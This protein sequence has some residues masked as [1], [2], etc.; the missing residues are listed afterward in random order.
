MW[1]DKGLRRF[2]GLLGEDETKILDIGSGRGE[3]AEILANEGKL[4]TAYDLAENRDFMDDDILSKM[5]KYSFDAVWCSHCLEHIGDTEEFLKRVRMFLKNNG[6]L[7][8]TVPPLKH[9]IVG[10]HVSL[11]NGGLLLYRLVLAG[12][13]CKHAILSQYDYNIS[14]ILRKRRIVLPDLVHDQ[15]DIG[16]L[17]EYFPGPIQHLIGIEGDSFSGDIAS[18]NWNVDIERTKGIEKA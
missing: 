10:G 9:E 17:R 18:C 11:W 1:A 16:A 4:V 3:H 12:F 7:C 6:L 15:G 5:N 2:I 13:D 8:I 14:V